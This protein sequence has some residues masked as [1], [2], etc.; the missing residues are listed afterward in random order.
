MQK[1]DNNDFMA[2][3]EELL[4]EQIAELGENPDEIENHEFVSQ[5][6]CEVHNDGTMV[7]FWRGMPILRL[8]PEKG[9]EGTTYWRIFTQEEHLQNSVH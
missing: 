5:M 9:D 7:Y 4:K 3:I 2:R 1:V 8:V 6:R